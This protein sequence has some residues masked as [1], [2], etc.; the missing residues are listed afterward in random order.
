LLHG[1]EVGALLGV[2]AV[3]RHRPATGGDGRPRMLASSVVSSRVLAKIASAHGFGHATTL[4]GFKWISRVPDLVYGYEEA[5]G[6]CVD[7]AHVR[8]K[9]G[10][11][12]AVLVARLAARLKAEGRTL[13]DALDDIAREHGLHVTDQLSARFGDVDRIGETMARLRVHPPRTLA[14]AGVARF[15]DLAAGVDGLPP[16]DGVVI[17]A[18]D[19]TRVIVRPSGTEPKIKCYLEVVETVAHDASSYQAGRARVAAHAKLERV[20][21][22]MRRALG[23]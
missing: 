21:A 3:S 17:L 13:V 8:D 11:S 14:G 4:T 10:I 18:G 12:A 20:K 16:T 19:G 5:L 2:E 22:D 6:Y 15:Q 23:L 1:D 9:D 7:P